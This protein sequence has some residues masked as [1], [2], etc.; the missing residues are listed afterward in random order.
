MWG[1]YFVVMTKEGEC[2]RIY[3]GSGTVSI[4]GIRCRLDTQRVGSLLPI[5]K[6]V[7]EYMEDGLAFAH[8][9]VWCRY[10]IAGTVERLRV[11]QEELR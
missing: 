9:G 10:D 11:M 4:R 8:L 3:I 2:T 7:K 1:V 5:P 6:H